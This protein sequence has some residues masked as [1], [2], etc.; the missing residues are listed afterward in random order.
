MCVFHALIKYCHRGCSCLLHLQYF[1]NKV[2]IIII[3]TPWRRVLPEK[4]TGPQLL[5]KFPEFTEPEGSLPHHKSPPTVPILSQSDPVHAPHPTSLRSI[6]I[7]FSRLRLG[8]PSGLRPWGFS[9]KFLYAPLLFPLHATCPAH[10]SVIDL[11]ARM[12]FG[13][14]YR[15]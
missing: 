8:L 7:L 1:K 10:L 14:E 6:L 13:E 4:P 11:I 2:I 15:V 12:G 9:T 3:I 5:K